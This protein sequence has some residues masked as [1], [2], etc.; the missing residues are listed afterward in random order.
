VLVARGTCAFLVEGVT[1]DPGTGRAVKESKVS[2]CFPDCAKP[3]TLE[4]TRML[5][6][7]QLH[8]EFGKTKAPVLLDGLIGQ[9][10]NATCLE[11]RLVGGNGSRAC[12]PQWPVVAERTGSV[13]GGEA[14][15]ESRSAP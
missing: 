15:C 12:P 10:R 4:E 3:L 1:S 7:D 8:R 6:V 2:Q 9:E 5:V 11:T 13:G 14:G